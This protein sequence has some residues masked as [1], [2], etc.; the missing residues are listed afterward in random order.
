MP[1]LSVLVAFVS[2]LV[3]GFAMRPLVFAL[4]VPS[5]QPFRDA[6]PACGADLLPSTAGSVHLMRGR[7]TA[8][9]TRLSPA[10][11]VPELLTAVVFAALAATG[12]TGWTAAAH[13]WLAAC[14]VA[15]AI[16]DVAVH[17]LPDVLTLPASAGTLLLLTG[18]AL[19]GENGSITRALAAAAA[20]GALY[21]VLVAVGMGM[22]DAKLVPAAGALL[23]WHS[24]TVVIRGIFVGYVVAFAFGAV[25]IVIG[26]ATRKTNVALGPFMIGGALAVSAL[27]S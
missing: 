2:G 14:G 20:L 6:C 17:R 11:G 15:L 16:I 23:G 8:C 4:S 13:Y 3:A 1:V 10:R 24:W 7:C 12:M 5:G 26:R 27:L 22:G 19:A 25:L 9:R 18:A 21:L